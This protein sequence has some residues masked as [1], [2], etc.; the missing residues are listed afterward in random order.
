MKKSGH[1]WAGRGD[2]LACWSG[3][4]QRPA[5]DF[6]FVCFDGGQALGQALIGGRVGSALSSAG[7]NANAPKRLL[8]VLGAAWAPGRG[9]AV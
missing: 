3:A 7:G 8:L 2:R 1:V 4:E 5:A 9:P 6:P